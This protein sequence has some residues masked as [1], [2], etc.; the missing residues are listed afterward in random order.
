MSTLPLALQKWR[1]RRANHMLPYHPH[2]SGQWCG[3]KQRGLSTRGWGC[4]SQTFQM[5]PRAAT[6]LKDRQSFFH[7]LIPPVWGREE[8]NGKLSLPPRATRQPEP[9][10]TLAYFQQGKRS[11][12]TGAAAGG[13]NERNSVKRDAEPFL[14]FWNLNCVAAQCLVRKHLLSCLPPTATP[15]FPGWW[16]SRRQRKKSDFFSLKHSHSQNCE[17][18]NHNMNC[19]IFKGVLLLFLRGTE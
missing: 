5:P 15:T 9:G 13:R 18:Q 2:Y 14:W 1:S 12:H 17:L 19:L 10:M 7:C 4:P 3:T 11:N 16:V 8:E 6:S